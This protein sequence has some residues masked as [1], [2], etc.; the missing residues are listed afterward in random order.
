MATTTVVDGEV[1]VIQCHVRIIC[2]DAHLYVV[3]CSV[4]DVDDFRSHQKGFAVFSQTVGN[5]TAFRN[6]LLGYF[7]VADNDVGSFVGNK[8][9]GAFI[10]QV[11]GGS[12]QHMQ[13]VGR[14]VSFVEG[15]REYAV[16]DVTDDLT[17]VFE[18]L[19]EPLGAIMDDHVE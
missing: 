1:V 7:L 4:T 18:R 17:G 6:D 16:V 3:G 12:G 19:T 5:R 8:V 9:D 2:G 10:G 13:R 15:E 11:V 14:N